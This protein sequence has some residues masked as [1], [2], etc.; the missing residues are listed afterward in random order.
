MKVMQC[1]VD[2]FTKGENVAK[3]VHRN[4]LQTTFAE[5]LKIY[6]ASLKECKICKYALSE[7]MESTMKNL[8]DATKTYF[9]EIMQNLKSIKGKL[10]DKW[11][12]TYP[13]VA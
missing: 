9:K 6:E 11:P 12:F 2:I 7:E 4:D 3:T 13:Q 5:K 8:D 1:L 10:I